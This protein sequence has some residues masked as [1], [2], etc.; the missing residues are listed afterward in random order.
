MIEKKFVGMKKDEFYVK[1]FVGKELGNGRISSIAIERTP[2][3]EKI[4]IRTSKPGLIIGRRGEKIADLTDKLKKHF[5]MENPHIEIMEIQHPDL[6]A[7]CVAEE[8]ALSLERFG[9]TSFKII[10]YK[11]LQRIKNAGAL[12]AEIRLSGKLPSERAKSWRFAFGYLKKTGDPVRFVERVNTVAQ[13]MPGSI[14][15]KVEIVPNIPIFNEKIIVNW[16]NLKSNMI[17]P[18]PAPVAVIAEPVAE[19]KTAKKR[20]KSESKKI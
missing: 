18:V 16:E 1:E 20:K 7:R 13:T 15:V 14:G 2:I 17:V 9:P 12:G 4:I 11:M 3:G 6:D 8:I 19:E 10:A 5:S